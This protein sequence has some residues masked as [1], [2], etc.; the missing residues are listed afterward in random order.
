MFTALSKEEYRNGRRKDPR[1]E[2]FSKRMARI[3]PDPAPN[4][5]RMADTKA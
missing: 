1:K 4:N 3:S 5:Q 2:G